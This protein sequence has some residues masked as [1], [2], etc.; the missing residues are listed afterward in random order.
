MRK[1]WIAALSLLL[2]LSVCGGEEAEVETPTTNLEYYEEVEKLEAKMY[3]LDSFK[4]TKTED[5]E[6]LVCDGDGYKLKVANPNPSEY[7]VNKDG[8][9]IAYRMVQKV[10]DQIQYHTIY[11]KDK[12]FY[13]EFSQMSG[14]VEPITGNNDALI[15][16]TV[17]KEIDTNYYKV[18]KEEDGENTKYTFTLDKAKDYNE[19]YPDDRNSQA[20]NIVGDY[21][22]QKFEI[23]V[24]KDGYI[25][26]ERLEE[27]IKYV[28]G[29]GE[30]EQER[31][32]VIHYVFYDFNVPNEIN[33]YF[34]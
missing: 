1:R 2:M 20:C 22:N 5:Y 29:D 30:T 34:I 15:M 18:T 27:T 25:I 4:I 17:F 32:N 14:Q 31:T 33:F 3:T 13:Q 8:E 7:E 26:E 21:V 24:N 6:A 28:A 10:E 11:Y 23:T 12:N 16:N 19:K 9:D